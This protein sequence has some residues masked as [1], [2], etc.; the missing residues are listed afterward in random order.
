MIERRSQ[1]WNFVLLSD[2]TK[3]KSIDHINPQYVGR[4]SDEGHL[5]S[6]EYIM[7]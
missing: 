3:L 1:Y 2:G 7:F 6:S 4:K 5:L